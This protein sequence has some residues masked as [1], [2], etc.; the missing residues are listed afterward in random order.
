M[1]RLFVLLTASLAALAMV[2]GPAAAGDDKP[3]NTKKAKA[4]IEDAFQCF[5]S[6]ALA[7]SYE[8]KAACVKDGDLLLE[9]ITTTGEANAAAAST[10]EIEIESIKFKSAK[11]A[12]VNFNLVIAG[13]VLEGIAPP[14]EALFAKD[15]EGKKKWLVSPV[16]V[17]DLTSLAN[18]AT[19]TEEP[20]ASI[21][22]G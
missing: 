15:A 16:M 2:A 3:K 22:T 10:T 4:Q 12:T 9:L 21:L 8:E 11:K 6:G 17:C 20:C 18:P 14:G 13:M 1:R 19:L 5:L 7:N